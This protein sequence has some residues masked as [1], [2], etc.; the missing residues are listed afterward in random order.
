MKVSI[1]L[2]TLLPYR[3][4]AS[5]LSVYQGTLGAHGTK[6]KWVAQIV[7]QGLTRAD[8]AWFVLQASTPLSLRATFTALT[9][10][11]LSRQVCTHLVQCLDPSKYPNWFYEHR[12]DLP[13]LVLLKDAHG[14]ENI[15]HVYD[16]LLDGS[17][18]Y[19]LP[20]TKVARARGQ[21]PAQQLLPDLLKL[22]FQEIEAS[23]ALASACRCC[24]GARVVEKGDLT[25][26]LKLEIPH[27]S[28]TG[29]RQRSSHAPV[30]SGI[31]CFCQALADR[32]AQKLLSLLASERHCIAKRQ[33]N[34]EFI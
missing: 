2:N 11:A 28:M 24:N 17:N 27:I 8:S 21:I 13:V 16:C 7:Q 33:P 10:F 20:Y 12:E 3:Q 30:I 32:F 15:Y 5:K 19:T 26:L 14:S 22:S 23:A 9:F 1:Q 31:G 34:K 29:Q 4:L 25:F 6:E 18:S